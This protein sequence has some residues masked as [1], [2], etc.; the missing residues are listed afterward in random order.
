M[1]PLT[2]S[3]PVHPYEHL[4]LLT[5]LQ[6]CELLAMSRST[7]WRRRDAGIIPPAIWVAGLLRVRL[8]D[9]TPLLDQKSLQ[10]TV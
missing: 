10:S 9:L 2:D 7:F 5:I 1:L 8:S 4:Q 6:A 3:T